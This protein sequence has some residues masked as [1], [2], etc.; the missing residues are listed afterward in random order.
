MW[1][2]KTQWLPPPPTCHSVVAEIRNNQLL[3]FPVVIILLRVRAN[4]ATEGKILQSSSTVLLFIRRPYL[5]FQVF[6]CCCCYGCCYWLSVRFSHFQFNLKNP[7]FFLFWLQIYWLLIFLQPRLMYILKNPLFVNKIYMIF[8][9]SFK[10]ARN[11]K[12]TNLSSVI[13]FLL[14]LTVDTWKWKLHN[15]YT[16][17]L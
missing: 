5:F 2:Y 3:I 17:T 1:H 8:A 4:T 12:I 13:Y 14:L 10:L 6:F 15:F 11:F 9:L 16:L 7:Y